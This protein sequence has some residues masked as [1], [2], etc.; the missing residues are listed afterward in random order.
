MP[1]RGLDTTIGPRDGVGGSDPTPPQAVVGMEM[2]Q[3]VPG[4]DWFLSVHQASAAMHRKQEIKEM[5]CI[6][7]IQETIGSQEQI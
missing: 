1:P 3:A 7:S 4:L 5:Q 6:E 2:A